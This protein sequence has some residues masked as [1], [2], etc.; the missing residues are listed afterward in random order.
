MQTERQPSFGSANSSKG[1]RNTPEPF[2]RHIT[3]A[4][5]N[6]GI[7]PG[8]NGSKKTTPPNL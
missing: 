1:S 6:K 7:L 5:A 8:G 3:K 4:I 2:G